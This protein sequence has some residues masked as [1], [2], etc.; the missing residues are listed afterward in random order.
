MYMIVQTCN[1]GHSSKINYSNRVVGKL[2]WGWLSRIRWSIGGDKWISFHPP[3]FNSVETY[4]SLDD[5]LAVCLI[6]HPQK[7]ERLL[8]DFSC[9]CERSLILWAWLYI[10]TTGKLNQMTIYFHCCYVNPYCN[11]TYGTSPFFLC[12][13]I[14]LY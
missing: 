10:Y 11:L 2:L 4:C 7:W 8:L 12:F 14:I 9:M 13:F 5:Q 6:Y 3:V 1:N